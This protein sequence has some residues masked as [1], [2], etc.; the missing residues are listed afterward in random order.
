MTGLRV[1]C[2]FLL[3]AGS[4][5]AQ[6]ASAPVMRSTRAPAESNP[7]DSKRD[8]ERGNRVF[9]IYCSYCHGA[10]GEG[11]RGADLTQGEFRYGSSDGEL[12][13]T[14]RN[15]IP[16][17]EMGWVR[18]SDDDVWRLVAFVKQLAQPGARKKASGDA[19]AGK[20]VYEGKGGC[21]ACHAINNRGGS[22]GPDLT[23]I[24]R[25]RGLDSLG[26][27]LLNPEADLPVNYRAVR[28]VT[29][30]GETVAGIR[31]N[32]DDFSIQLHDT[33]GNLR[34]FLKDKLK[35]IRRD[36]PS[37]MPAYGSILTKKEIGD[38]LAYLSSLRGP[39]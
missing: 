31:L 21:A 25:R 3:L 8:I 4:L 13:E 9:Q 6:R 23:D 12:F 37:L 22:L 33:A 38:L 35:E 39:R 32:E 18:A 36:N 17:S 30:A 29:K 1:G 24:G 19:A 2:W 14:I 27:S 5:C 11:G 7:F 16:G 26:E 34:S 28:V 10:T 15:G 20:V